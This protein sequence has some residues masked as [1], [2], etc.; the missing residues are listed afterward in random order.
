M[1]MAKCADV[2]ADICA[3]QRQGAEAKCRGKGKCTAEWV[4][5]IRK[6][7]A[8]HEGSSHLLRRRGHHAGALH[9]EP[10]AEVGEQLDL[11]DGRVGPVHALIAQPTE[12]LAAAACRSRR[13]ELQVVRG[14][15]HCGRDGRWVAP[16]D[17]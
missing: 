4:E 1:G 3:V 14:R 7:G 16:A 10:G 5:K 11:I 13:R 6:S 8:A 15:Q 9:L 17:S 12:L 2:G